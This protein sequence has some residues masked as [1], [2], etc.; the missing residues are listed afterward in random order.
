MATPDAPVRAEALV[1][2]HDAPGEPPPGS[3]LWRA[4]ADNHRMN[5]LLW[6]EED[7]ARR[8]HVAD[9]E[10]AANKRAIDGYNQKRN[11]AIER[12]D[13]IL[14]LGLAKVEP[15]KNS[16]LNSETPGAMIDRL[17]ILSLKIHHMR[18]QTERT[19]V[20]PA[21]IEACRS[22]LGRLVEQRT[23]LAGCLDRLLAE[24][25]R[26]ETRF[27][28]YRQFKMYN[29]PALNPAIYGERKR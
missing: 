2:F 11:D 14:L 13:E 22:K 29:D 1:A 12:I 27:K 15:G 10:I 8:R 25:E 20:D 16:R 9:S 18:L 28:V 6:K 19:D 26:G 5:G 4:I 3:E 17:S 7:L 24:A 21:H 23:D